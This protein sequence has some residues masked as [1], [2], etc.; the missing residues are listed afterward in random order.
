MTPN[1]GFAVSENMLQ[2]APLTWSDTGVT[3]LQSG[4]NGTRVHRAHNT[5]T[6][7][8]LARIN[9]YKNIICRRTCRRGRRRDFAVES[10]WK[11]SGLVLGHDLETCT[12]TWRQTD[13]CQGSWVS[14][15]CRICVPCCRCGGYSFLTSLLAV[16]THSKGH[17]FQRVT[18]K[19]PIG[20]CDNQLAAT[21]Y[22][23]THFSG[24][25]FWP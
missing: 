20:Y 5:G 19:Q 11:W 4:S 25:R 15:T 24:G 18:N 8:R 12:G 16:T 14:W 10:A 3:V 6:G 23:H 9:Q 1:Q 2:T 7:L 17:F 22:I 13:S 21:F